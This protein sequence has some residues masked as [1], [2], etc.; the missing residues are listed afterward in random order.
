MLRLM[1]LIVL[2]GAALFAFGFYSAQRDPQ[3]AAYRIAVPGLT[4]QVRIVQLSDSHA[5]A[6]DMRPSRLARVASIINARKPD[7]IL[8]TGD[9]IS[10]NPDK[11]DADETRA[12][13]APFKALQAPLGV[14]AV[15]GN[16]DDRF[17]TAA[18]M[19]AAHIRLLIGERADI[20]PFFLVGVDDQ[21]SGSPA[22]EGMRK[23]IRRA[24]PG[25]PIVVVAHEPVF[26]VWLQQR[27]VLM[28]A[29]HTH[30]GQI[31]LP[32]IGSWPTL[33]YYTDHRRGFYREGRHMLVVSSGLGTTNL[34]IRIGVPPEIAEIT[35][36]PGV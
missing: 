33:Q 3:V 2:A 15:M 35:L 28:I 22:V 10:G 19:A 12:A 13:I 29:G 6:I 1:W 30:G 24:P 31:Y 8:L 36:V 9:Y 25:K 32:F 34:P 20:G 18:A 11:W 23:A 17:K 16:H 26:M 7:L 21:T 5:S 14:F 27:P 4:R